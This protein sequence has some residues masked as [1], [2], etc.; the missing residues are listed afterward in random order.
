LSGGW[1]QRLLMDKQDLLDRIDFRDAYTRLGLELHGNGSRREVKALCPFHDDHSPSLGINLDTGFYRC[2]VCGAK[3]DL[4][5]FYQHHHKCDFPA[6]LRELAERYGGAQVTKPKD[7]PATELKPIPEELPHQYWEALQAYPAGLE[8]L[9][10]DRGFGQS[11]IDFWQIGYDGER[12]TLPIRDADGKLRNIKRYLPRCPKAKPKWLSWASGYG[13]ARLWPTDM[14]TCDDVLLCEGEFD[15]ILA[16]QHGFNALTATCGAGKWNDEW[17]GLF[18]GKVVTIAYDNDQAGRDGA[19]LVA[20]SIAGKAASVRILQWPPAMPDK[21]DVT[22]WFVG[23]KQDAK[24]LQSLIE[25]AKEYTS[26]KTRKMPRSVKTVMPQTGFLATY[27]SYASELTDAPIEFHLATGLS[28]L[29]AATGNR[30][31]FV[32]WGQNVC[33]NLWSVL[34]APSGFYRKSTAMSIGI[35]LLKQAVPDATLP[36]DFSREGLMDSMVT[37]PSGLLTPYEFGALIEHMRKEYMRGTM[38]ALTAIYDCPDTYEMKTKGNGL[39]KIDKPAI[40]ILGA[41]TIDWLQASVKDLKGGFIPRFLFWPATQKGEWKGMTPPPN[42]ILQKSMVDFLRDV[43]RQ[44]A[45]IEFP[46]DVRGRFNEW[47]RAHEEGFNAD[48]LPAVLLGFYTRMTTYVAKMG[49]LYYISNHRKPGIDIDSLESAI[50]VIDYLKSHLTKL[51]CEDFV[52]TKE[53]ALL[54]EI[55]GIIKQAGKIEH[56]LLL[57]N[58][59]MLKVDL[60]RVI[61]T[62][63]D[64]EEIR[65]T[66]EKTAGRPRKVYELT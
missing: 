54:K 35:R 4:F 59:R 7:S 42:Q 62:L 27:M 5:T 65:V 28:I 64:S 53:G 11:T 1:L 6:A 57:K 20:E 52:Y 12:L 25:R 19:L 50:R 41:S 56:Q 15:A 63:L 22:D 43:S 30:V 24:G 21:G 9:H 33:L 13:K 23:M 10:G 55:K 26:A 31:S 29:A 32:S 45:Q 46:A 37:K 18:E 61:M 17:A 3:G 47:T 2:P 51:V 36:D 38:E 66:H 58:S 34:I 40:N 60:D 14:L 44:D 8:Y 39:R 16:F 49:V 48:R